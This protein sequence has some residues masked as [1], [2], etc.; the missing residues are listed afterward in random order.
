[1]LDSV[2]LKLKE[3]RAS[4]ILSGVLMVIMGFLFVLKPRE[5]VNTFSALMGIILVLIGIVQI[6][7]KIVD[8][9]NRS[10]GILVGALLAI[11]GVWIVYNREFAAKILP[12]IVG[13]VLVVSSIQIASM[14]F[15]AKA[16]RMN[17]WWI[18]LIA[19]ILD[20]IIGAICVFR[21]FQ[22][23]EFQVW[24]VGVMLIYVGITS[25]LSAVRLRSHE[26]IIE[27]T[28]ISEE[29]L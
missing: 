24:V 15:S 22:V 19:A 16:K 21:A 14:A 12:I 29:D 4:I 3:I 5:V 9:T 10:S 6:I 28:I 2:M 17:R 18:L 26:R 7:G 23:V 20:F 1:M 27:G 25:I 11:V 13:V 8:D